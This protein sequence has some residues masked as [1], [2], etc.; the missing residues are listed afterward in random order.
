[1]RKEHHNGGDD[2]EQNFWKEAKVGINKHSIL[3]IHLVLMRAGFKFMVSS[4][5]LSSI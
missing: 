2:I 3:L 1:M 4:L 5:S